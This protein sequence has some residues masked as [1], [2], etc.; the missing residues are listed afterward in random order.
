MPRDVLRKSLLSRGN[1]GLR[2]RRMF[3]MFGEEQEG[4]C[5]GEGSQRAR[6]HRALQAVVRGLASE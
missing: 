1:M 5:E 6:V 4:L 3:G 2:D